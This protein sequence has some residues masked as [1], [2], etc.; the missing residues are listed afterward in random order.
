MDNKNKKVQYR[1]LL[2]TNRFAA[3][4]YKTMAYL[5]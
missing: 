4:A 5:F 3:Q 2:G 1:I